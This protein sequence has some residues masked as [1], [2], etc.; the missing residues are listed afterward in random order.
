M[1]RCGSTLICQMLA[2]AGKNIV[3]SEASPIETIL[4]AHFR[5]AGLSEVQRVQ[6]LRWMVAVLGWRRHPEE[7]NLFVKF[8][9]WDTLF[10]PLIER[11]FPEVPWVFLYREPIEV[12]ASQLGH[13]GPQMIPGLL[14]PALFGWNMPAVSA[15]TLDEYGARALAKICEAALAQAQRGSGRLINYRQLPGSVWPVLMKFW[16][17]EFSPDESRRMLDAARLNAKNP[18]LPFEADSQAKRQGAPE[19]IRAISRQWLEEVYG[20]L[21]GLRME[22]GFC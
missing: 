16:G 20:K 8:D 19:A 18:V 17:V 22:R 13:R 21:E 9:C 14:D 15:M 3:I 12:L 1:S 2:A 4:R 7:K 5:D 10:L 6:W 11:A